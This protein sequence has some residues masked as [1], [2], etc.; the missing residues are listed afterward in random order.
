MGMAIMQAQIIHQTID[1]PWRDVY[2][3][4]SDPWKIHLWAAGLAKGL[5]PHGDI[6]IADGG[7]IGMVKIKFRPNNDL[8]VIDHIVTMPDGYEVYNALRVTPN[9]SGA[10]VA[11]TLLRLPDMS[12]D[13]FEHDAALVAADLAMLKLLIENQ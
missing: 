10:L 4:A 13:D 12:E 6:W 1:R 2:D 5:M 7:A 8:G 9:G 3:F 11:F